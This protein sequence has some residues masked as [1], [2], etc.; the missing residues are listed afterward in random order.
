MRHLRNTLYIFT[1]DAYATLDGENIVVKQSGREMGRVPLH[2]LEAIF[3]FSYM[4]ASPALMGTCAERGIGLSFFTPRGRFLARSCGAQQGNVLLRKKQYAWSESEERSLAVAKPFIA[5][6]IYNSR[7]VLE[8]GAI[9]DFALRPILLKVLPRVWRHLWRRYGA[10]TTP[11]RCVVLKEMR[12]RRIS[13]LWA[14]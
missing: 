6:K 11:P 1:E 12:L 13:A 4:G 8:R 10:V 3:C 2:T 9:M 5:G 7:W 14:N